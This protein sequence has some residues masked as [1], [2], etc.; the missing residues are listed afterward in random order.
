MQQVEKETNMNFVFGKRD[1]HAI[2]M[3]R[4]DRI[5]KDAF[6]GVEENVA[7]KL[8]D[9]IK[10][11]YEKPEEF[12]LDRIVKNMRAV[13]DEEEG[14][15]MNIARTETNHISN[16]ARENSYSQIKDSDKLKFKWIGPD[17]ERTTPVC[18]E[19]KRITAG[20]VFLPDLK[21]KIQHVAAKYGYTARDFTPHFQCRHT[22]I[23]TAKQ[24]ERRRIV[25]RI[26]TNT[27]EVRDKYVDAD[28]NVDIKEQ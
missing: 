27:F 22:F 18:E 8:G 1:E 12:T 25:K 13:A 21:Q 6:N 28:R 10:N 23:R 3:L 9:V 14:H 24:L 19:L 17:D 26:G 15:L 16:I 2:E 11:A 5:F 4:Q 7:K 20:G